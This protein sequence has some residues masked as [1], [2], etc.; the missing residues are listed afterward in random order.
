[1][2]PAWEEGLSTHYLPQ[3]VVKRVLAGERL[4]LVADVV[5]FE[6]SVPCGHLWAP[7]SGDY[8]VLWKGQIEASADKSPKAAKPLEEI[9]I[10]TRT[11]WCLRI[12]P[13]RA[14]WVGRG[15]SPADS[16]SF[17]KGTLDFENLRK[18]LRAVC[19]SKGTIATH[20]AVT[21]VPRG[22]TSASSAYCTDHRLMREL[23]AKAV[24]AGDPRGKTLGRLYELN[25]PLPDDKES[26][27]MLGPRG[28]PTPRRKPC[29]WPG[30]PN[31][32]APAA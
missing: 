14:G 23:F 10:M 13:G 26:R 32:A 4:R 22:A 5:I 31:V 15:A 6:T 18:R 30:R 19:V 3:A 2:G 29:G 27:N 24:K 8:R 16:T 20:C 12:F 21:F 9:H 7:A 25:P 1:M 17:P 28:L 11:A